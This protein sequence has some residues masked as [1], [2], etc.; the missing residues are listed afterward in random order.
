LAFWKDWG[1]GDRGQEDEKELISDFR[2]LGDLQPDKLRVRM[3]YKRSLR[4][5]YTF[6]FKNKAE[7]NQRNQFPH[8]FQTK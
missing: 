5:R 3:T 7:Q 6:P 2:S 8:I 4:L 1:L